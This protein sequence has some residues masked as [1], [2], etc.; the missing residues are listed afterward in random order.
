[1][2]LGEINYHFSIIF[3]GLKGLTK[4]MQVNNSTNTKELTLDFKLSDDIVYYDLCDQKLNKGDL[5]GLE[6]EVVNQRNGSKVYSILNLQDHSKLSP[7]LKEY[8][9]S[10]ERT[11]NIEA[12]A[13]I[14]RGFT[15]KL[16]MDLYF[17]L[18]LPLVP[19]KTFSKVSDAENWIKEMQKNKISAA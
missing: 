13:I 15:R 19:T 9:I 12:E 3:V 10:E 1:M 7:E 17:Q 16:M 14:V 11:W 4:T 18:N 2:T 6:Q 8:L 5:I